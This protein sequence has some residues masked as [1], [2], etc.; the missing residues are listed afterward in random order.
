MALNIPFFALLVITVIFTVF[1]PVPYLIFVMYIPLALA[2]ID[3]YLCLRFLF[4]EIE[5]KSRSKVAVNCVYLAV[6]SVIMVL[7]GI[8]IISCLTYINIPF[9]F[10]FLPYLTTTYIPVYVITRIVYWIVTDTFASR[11]LSE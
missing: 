5:P 4:L 6:S 7:L 2:E 10:R 9:S 11:A 3:V 1:F 8:H